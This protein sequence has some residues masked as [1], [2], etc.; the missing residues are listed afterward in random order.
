MIVFTMHHC[1]R[2]CAS[3]T[4]T[5]RILERMILAVRELGFEFISYSDFRR[6]LAGDFKFERRHVLLTFDDGYWD[7]YAFAYPVLKKHG[8]P[9]VIFLVAGSILDAPRVGEP[10]PKP[11]K[12]IIAARDTDLFLRVSEAREMF[13]SGLIEF[14]GHTFSHFDCDSEDEAALRSEF[15]RSL[16]KMKELFGERDSYGFCWPRGHFNALSVK[17]LK[18]CGYKFAFSTIDGPF[19]AGDDPYLI[20][21][22]DISTA[23]KGERDYLARIRKK[24]LVYSAP[25]FGDWYSR[26]GSRNSKYRLPK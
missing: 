14:D 22:V 24:L 26:F 10:A 4:I 8:V 9:A 19:C 2:E 5:P 25:F 17:A 15:S 21:R 6:G 7:N 16:E 13:E 11:Q 20:R 23:K 1:H 3:L 12:D 18:E